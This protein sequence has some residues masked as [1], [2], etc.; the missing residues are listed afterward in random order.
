MLGIY[1]PI[2]KNNKPKHY[3]KMFLSLQSN[4]VSL[5]IITQ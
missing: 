4:K 1:F 5:D 2:Q 3:L